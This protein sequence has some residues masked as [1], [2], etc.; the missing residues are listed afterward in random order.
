MTSLDTLRN[1][2]LN[3]IERYEAL[4]GEA[5][6]KREAKV[7]TIIRLSEQMR[8]WL[9]REAEANGRSINGEV[10]FRLKKLME[11]ESADKRA[12]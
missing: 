11:T 8:E 7:P 5:V 1:V 10:I 12:A 2:T 3:N 6:K 4:R 9:C